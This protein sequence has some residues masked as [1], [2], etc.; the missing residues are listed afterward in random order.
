MEKKK[1]RQN[2]AS[3]GEYG[4]IVRSIK[5]QPRSP[6]PATATKQ[7]KETGI[8]IEG[9]FTSEIHENGK[10]IGW[11]SDDNLTQVKIDNEVIVIRMGDNEWK[12]TKE[13][14]NKAIKEKKPIQHSNIN[15]KTSTRT[16]SCT[17]DDSTRV[18]KQLTDSYSEWF[19]P[20]GEEWWQWNKEFR[21]GKTKAPLIYARSTGNDTDQEEIYQEGKRRRAQ[22]V[23]SGKHEQSD[24]TLT[25]TGEYKGVPLHPR[26]KEIMELFEHKGDT[27]MNYWPA[28][29]AFWKRLRSKWP[30]GKRTG[31]MGLLKDHLRCISEKEWMWWRRLLNLAYE[32]TTECPFE[33][34]KYTELISLQKEIGNDDTAKQRPIQLMDCMANTW[35]AAG[36]KKLDNRRES[37]QYKSDM[38]VGFTRNKSPWH[39]HHRVHHTQPWKY[40][41]LTNTKGNSCT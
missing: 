19:A 6:I 25:S 23:R 21:E 40:K 7:L 10:V 33:R 3:T 28:P 9:T 38:Q 34:W 14:W 16:I 31:E 26:V 13:H 41:D 22:L 1:I 12:S 36:I 20:H 30:A 2:M 39:V 37:E 29:K 27:T 15:I 8:E 4:T 18:A 17:T 11:K 5:A 32:M 35:N 24:N